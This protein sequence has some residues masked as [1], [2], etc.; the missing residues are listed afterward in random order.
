[1]YLDMQCGCGASFV[2]Q[3]AS[4]ELAMLYANRFTSAHQQCGY[5][6]NIARDVDDETFRY[7]YR[8]REKEAD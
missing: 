3:D 6:N 1:M 7:D 2:I 8:K 5:M 4:D